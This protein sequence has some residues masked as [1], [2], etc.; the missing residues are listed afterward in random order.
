MRNHLNCAP[1]VVSLGE[2]VGL[3]KGCEQ[4]WMTPMDA[5]K[6]SVIRLGQVCSLGIYRD[7]LEIGID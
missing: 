3:P 6:E 5:R 1:N 2:A 4:R 7:K